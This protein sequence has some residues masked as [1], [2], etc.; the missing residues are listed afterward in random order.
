MVYVS[1]MLPTLHS[2]GGSA[3]GFEEQVRSALQHCERILAAAGSSLDQVVQCT[4]YI[5]GLHHWP[6]FNRIYSERFGDHKP[7]RTVLPVAELHYGALVE[8][9]MIAKQR[10]A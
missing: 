3:D 5:V 10:P 7:S 9:Q 1:G 4:A 6:L 8:V 2:S